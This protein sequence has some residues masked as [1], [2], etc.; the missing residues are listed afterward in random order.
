MVR[1]VTTGKIGSKPRDGRPWALAGVSL[2]LLFRHVDQVPL[3]RAGTTAQLAWLRRRFR[4]RRFAAALFLFLAVHPLAA[5][6][7]LA[8]LRI[9][10]QDLHLDLVAD[11]DDVFGALDLAVGQLGDMQE[12]FEARLQLDEDAEVGELGHLTDLRVAGVVPAGGLAFS[13][14]ERR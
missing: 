6:A 1:G 5:Q 11:L 4:G 2:F 3:T 12:P 10:A 14:A 9:D 8:L 13:W 7:D